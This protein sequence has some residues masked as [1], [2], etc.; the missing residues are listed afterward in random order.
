MYKMDKFFVPLLTTLLLLAG[1]VK[2][3]DTTPTSSAMLRV[4]DMSKKPVQ[5][6]I[7]AAPPKV[8][9]NKDILLTIRITTPSEIEVTLPHLDDRLQGFVL[10]GAF[11]TEPFTRDGKTVWERKARLTPILANEY[12]VAPMAILYKDNSK[13]PA[14]EEWFATRA[15]VFEVVPPVKGKIKKDIDVVFNPIWI[16]P[17]FKTVALYFI[18]IISLIGAIIIAWKLLRRIRH[19]IELA[20]MSPKERALKELAILMAKKLI[21]KNLVKEFY[22]ELTMIV[23]RYIERRHAIRAPEQTTEEFLSA[24][25][26]DSRFPNEVLKKLKTFLESADLVKFARQNPTPEAVS[27]SIDTARDY[28]KTDSET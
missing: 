19:N 28:I 13:S 11:D 24:V 23:R 18:L 12:R 10:N 26:D 17:P 22:L 27:K 20:R 4:E 25:S 6:T 14:V 2:H 5:V 16:Y 8:E 1:C 15:I 7:T 9:L 21:E 3:V